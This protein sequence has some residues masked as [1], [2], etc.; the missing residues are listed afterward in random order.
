MK[1]AEYTYS[2][3]TR[4]IKCNSSPLQLPSVLWHCWLCVP[5]NESKQ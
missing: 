1:N 4:V 5:G 2:N 3:H